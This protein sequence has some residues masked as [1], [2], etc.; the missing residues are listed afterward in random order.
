MGWDLDPKFRIVDNRAILAFIERVNPS[1][2]DDIAT[3]LIKSA[4]DLPD[5]KWYCPDTRRYAYVVLH[6]QHRIFGIAFGMAALAFRL[7]GALHPEALAAGGT[8]YAEI[9]E[10]W[11]EW[12]RT[13]MLDTKR[14]CKAAHDY[15]IGGT[16]DRRRD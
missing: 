16:A 5:V 12:R 15:A 7:P 9:D 13:T 1:A 11:M 4:E 14:W 10:E 8:L 2:H 6:T 3:I